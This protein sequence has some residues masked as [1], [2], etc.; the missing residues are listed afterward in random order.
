LSGRRAPL[1]LAGRLAQQNAFEERAINENTPLLTIIVPAY[2]EQD[3][4]PDSLAKIAE[5]VATQPYE[6]E[7]IV[8]DNNSSDRTPDIV[9]AFAADH[10]YTRLIHEKRQGKGS[11]VR[12]GIFAG[13]GGYLFIC[14]SDLAMPIAEV[15]KF[16]PPQREGIDVAIASREGPGARRYNEPHYRH[17]MGRVFNLIVQIVAL[18]GI[19]DTQCGFKCF[20]RKVGHDIFDRQTM[21]GFGFDVEILVIA[22]RRGYRIVEV[23]INW[24]YDPGT[25]VNLVRDPFRMVREVLQVRLNA[26][27]GLYDRR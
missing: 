14:D 25:S 13:R 22:R 23:P 19:N 15:T 10:P 5:F 3:R 2:N 6:I 24:Y 18:P 9:R 26:W 1:H 17:L 20:R 27:R 21:D 8:V 12:A 7:L 16:L 4:L 11:A